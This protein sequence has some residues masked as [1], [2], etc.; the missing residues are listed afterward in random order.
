MKL[1]NLIKPR[2]GILSISR[3]KGGKGS[4]AI[5]AIKLSSNES[6]LGPSD[7]AIKAYIDSAKSLSIYPDGNSTLLKEKIAELHNINVNNII[8]GAGSDE[9]LN[10]IAAAYLMPGDE[11][12][13]SEHAFL[14]YKIITLAN[15]GTPIAAKE[16]G[17]KANIDNII[18]CVTKKTKIVFIANPNNPTG[19]YLNKNELY[20][21]RDRLPESVLLVIDGAYAEYAQE[22][23][24][25]DGKSLISDAVNTVMTRT[26][27][28]VYAL[29]A[30][31]IG[32]AYAPSHIIETLN[33]IRG[34][35]NLSTAAINAGAAAL[36]DQDHVKK[37]VDFNTEEKVNLLEEYREIMIPTT[38]GAANFLLLDLTNIDFIGFMGDEEIAENMNKYLIHNNIYVRNVA[39]YGL[40]CHLR[41]TIGKREQNN[42]VLE[43]I[44]QYMRQGG[45]P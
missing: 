37:S 15:N 17:L 7:R 40:S 35:F 4:Q 32:W 23:D 22:E 6:P 36:D 14:L 33:K 38:G 16:D 11:V 39:D 24:Y 1:S 30:L 34:P 20:E 31:R 3:Y 28:K 8:C 26:F 18:S 25:I 27:S 10:L 13:F 42:F 19:S 21:L 45:F 5:G 44:Q 2:D 41:I 12:I 43:K 9:I 29:A